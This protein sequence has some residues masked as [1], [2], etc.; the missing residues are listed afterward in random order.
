MKAGY[1]K[2]FAQVQTNPRRMSAAG[3]AVTNG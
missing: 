2:L 3:K 1:P